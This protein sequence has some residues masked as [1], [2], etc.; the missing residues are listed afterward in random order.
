MDTDRN[1]D[2]CTCCGY[3]SSCGEY[4]G[5]AVCGW[6]C[7]WAQESGPDFPLGANGRITL[8]E[9]QHNFMRFGNCDGVDGL[10]R[11][12]A[13][14]NYRRDPE[15]RPFAL[16]PDPVEDA[17]A[18]RR[19]IP[20]PEPGARPCCG[21]NTILNEG[22]GCRICGFTFWGVYFHGADLHFDELND[23]LSLREV[24]RNLQRFGA[25]SP[26]FVKQ[27]RESGPDDVRDPT[28]KPLP[29]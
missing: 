26:S 21:F 4:V 29:L 13:A 18:W 27:K 12:K 25:F 28:W 24:Q 19:K 2:T 8:R 14:S 16:E 7:D 3:K 15:W 1:W 9:A 5:C 23:G 10:N 6:Q 20:P 11:G 17:K 22:D